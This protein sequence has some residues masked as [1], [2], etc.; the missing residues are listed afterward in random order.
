MLEQDMLSEKIVE[1]SIC[2]FVVALTDYPLANGIT[3]RV[4]NF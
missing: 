1:E 2:P 4:S 3:V